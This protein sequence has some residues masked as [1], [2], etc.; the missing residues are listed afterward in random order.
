MI[1][2]VDSWDFELDVCDALGIFELSQNKKKCLKKLRI[3]GWIWIWIWRRIDILFQNKKM[4]SD[5]KGKL[6][7]S[8]RLS[9]SEN[10]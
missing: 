7:I 9:F 4:Q 8:K 5:G 10:I 3:R 6:K 2:E 1:D